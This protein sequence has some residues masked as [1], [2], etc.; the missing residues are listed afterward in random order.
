M[1]KT[2][3]LVGP[4][5]YLVVSGC[6]EKFRPPDGV[7]FPLII[8]VVKAVVVKAVVARWLQER[9]SHRWEND[10]AVVVKAVV[11]RVKAV[12]VF[13][14]I[15][16]IIAVVVKAVVAMVK[17]VVVFPLIIADP[18]WNISDVGHK[19]E[20]KARPNRPFTKDFGPWDAFKSDRAYL[21]RCRQWLKALYDV[22]AP[23]AFLFFWCSYRYAPHILRVAQKVGW[24]D[25]N[26]YVWCKT[27]A[28]PMFGNNNCLASVEM[29]LIL[30]KGKPLFHFARGK[31]PP[32]YFESP[33]GGGAERVKDHNGGAVNLAQK[34]LALT[35]LWVDWGSR[36]GDW[37]LDAFAGT[38]TV[39]VAALRLGRNACAVEL[40]PALAHQ[41]EARVLRE[42][43]G[44]GGYL[45]GGEDDWRSSA[46][47]PA[48]TFLPK[49]PAP[50]LSPGGP[51][52]FCT[53]SCRS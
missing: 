48:I 34:P 8:A 23:D 49:T 26:F 50:T 44:A 19:R 33:Q 31:Q 11:A 21:A 52:N 13:P 36:P 9:F 47:G 28:L 32:N 27:N 25:H 30:A 45:Q 7:V 53:P 14:L 12:V 46:C 43:P 1:T 29:S 5:R 24:R 41:I 37:V 15:I 18:P 3:Y 4:P 10:I 16:L 38:G 40:D 42:C 17:A 22:A 20:R 6:V 2:V 39:T 51:R 35:S